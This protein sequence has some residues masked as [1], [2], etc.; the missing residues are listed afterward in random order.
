MYYGGILEDWTV[1]VK[2]INATRKTNVPVRRIVAGRRSILKVTETKTGSAF[3][4]PTMDQE[5][6]FSRPEYQTPISKTMG[7]GSLRHLIL[8]GKK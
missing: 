2:D 3:P 8:K 7:N 4:G 1:T 6:V 5:D